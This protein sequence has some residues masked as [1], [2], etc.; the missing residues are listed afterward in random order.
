MADIANASA[1]VKELFTPLNVLTQKDFYTLIDHCAEASQLIGLDGEGDATVAGTT[2]LDRKDAVLKLYFSENCFNTKEG[3]LSVRVGTGALTQ[4][5][6]V[7]IQSAAGFEQAPLLALKAGGGFTLNAGALDLQH[8]ACFDT[9][10]GALN[11][12]IDKNCLMKA[13]GSLSLVIK[14]DWTGVERTINFSYNNMYLNLDSSLTIN[15]DGKLGVN[16]DIF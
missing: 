2:G 7:K 16:L 11:L 4:T 5:L 6:A 1:K 3:E 10:G 13:N 8:A 15:A 14:A 12:N 9:G